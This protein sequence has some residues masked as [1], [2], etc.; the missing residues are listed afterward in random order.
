MRLIRRYALSW[1]QLSIGHT[2]VLAEEVLEKFEK[3]A[4]RK[5]LVNL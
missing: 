4:W 1:D 5:W 2:D 3:V